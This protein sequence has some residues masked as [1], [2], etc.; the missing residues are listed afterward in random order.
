MGITQI[1]LENEDGGGGG[2]GDRESHQKL[3]GEITL[4]K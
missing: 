1:L 3:L 4:V 2:G